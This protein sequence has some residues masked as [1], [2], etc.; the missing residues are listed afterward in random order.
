M[1][2]HKDPIP[3]QGISKDIAPC[4]YLDEVLLGLVLHLLAIEDLRN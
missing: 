4:A 2:P 3:D 1:P